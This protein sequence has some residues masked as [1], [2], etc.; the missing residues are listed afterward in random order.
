MSQKNNLIPKII[1]LTPIRNE[2][3]ILEN[4]LKCTSLWADTI[5]IA[6]QES[7][8]GSREIAK[9]FEK[10]KLVDN[11]SGY[12]SEEVRQ[13]ILIEESRKITGPKIILTL[14]ADEFLTANFMESKEWENI[15]NIEPGTV[16]KFK[17]T[18]ITP[19]FLQYWIPPF[20]MPWGFYDDGSKH[21][22]QVIHSSRIPVLDGNSN[23]ILLQDIKVMH[24]QYIDWARMESKHRWY[25]CWERINK[26]DRS[27]ISIYRQ[28]HHM[29]SIRRNDFK[30][31]PGS[32]FK[33]YFDLGID[34]TKIKKEDNYYWDKL[35]LD[36]FEKY[37]ASFFSKEAIWDIDWIEKARL[38]KYSN[39]EKFKD[40]RDK[41]K[42]FLHWWLKKTQPN[43]AN[44]FVRG[45]D[46]ILRLLVKW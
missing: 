43:S 13:K 18:N 34:L 22:G 42:K 8:D 40:P 46:K 20:E 16:I 44:F 12:F 41:T 39:F 2:S 14:D 7:D 21:F 5:I 35:V 4:F 26:P 17:F 10:V 23:S 27:A 45:V 36:Y 31:V 28:Y 38:Y 15:L 32:W 30:P 3:W 11:K 37:G 9:T 19:D 6:D 24:F 25:Q 29:Y 33:G 1:C